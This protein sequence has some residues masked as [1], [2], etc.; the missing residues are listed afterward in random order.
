MKITFTLGEL[1]SS[2]SG[3]YPIGVMIPMK[4]TWYNRFR[5]WM[6]FK[7]FPFEFKEWTE[8]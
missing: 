7:F 1:E 2:L 6:F 3:A 4:R 5:F 8:D